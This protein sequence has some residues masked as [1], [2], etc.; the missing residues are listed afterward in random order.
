MCKCGNVETSGAIDSGK[1]VIPR[2][3]PLLEGGL[4]GAPE[5]LPIE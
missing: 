2:G 1:A 5:A 3:S 4:T